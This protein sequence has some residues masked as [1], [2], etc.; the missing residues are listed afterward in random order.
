MNANLVHSF[1][2]ETSRCAMEQNPA[3]FTKSNRVTRFPSWM[4]R[5]FIGANYVLDQFHRVGRPLS[6]LEV[7]IDCGQMLHYMRIALREHGLEFRDVI[8]SWTGVDLD[9]TKCADAEYDDLLR[10]NIEDETPSVSYDVCILLHIIEHLRKPEAAMTNLARCVRPEVGYIIGVPC[11]LDAVIPMRERHL[12]AHTNRNGHVSAISRARVHRI[13][14][15][16]EMDIVDE[17]NAFLIRA[18]GMWLEDYAA[19]QSLNSSLGRLLT[20]MPG[21]YYCHAVKAAA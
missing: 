5:Y 10:M 9:I 11:H 15:E 18:S 3:L 17:R 14:A 20:G 4:L 6:V 7:G 13:A 12:R 21:E 1:D 2:I 8:S 19:W 16:N